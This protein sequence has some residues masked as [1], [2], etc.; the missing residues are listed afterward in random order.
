MDSTR[1][2]QNTED[3]FQ[4]LINS[5]CVSMK[6]FISLVLSNNP[7]CYQ[8]SGLPCKAILTDQCSKARLPSVGTAQQKGKLGEMLFKIPSKL[9]NLWPF[10]SLTDQ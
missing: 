8:Y 10:I 3:Y 1:W 7:S 9:K 4:L 2:R 5:L 6:P